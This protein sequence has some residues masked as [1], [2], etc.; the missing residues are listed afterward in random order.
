[1]IIIP[2]KKTSSLPIAI[3][4]DNL[5]GERVPYLYGSALLAYCSQWSSASALTHSLQIPILSHWPSSMKHMN[6]PAPHF[7][8]K[9]PSSANE[10]YTMHLLSLGCLHYILYISVVKWGE[11]FYMIRWDRAETLSHHHSC[12]ICT[13]EKA[14]HIPMKVIP[15]PSES[16]V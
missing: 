5:N 10:W 13:I 4:Q 3:S 7:G 9:C 14:T 11:F 6:G 2:T 8:Q 15:I 1:M 12:F 16:I